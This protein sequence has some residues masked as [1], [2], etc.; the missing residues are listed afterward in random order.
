MAGRADDDPEK[1]FNPRASRL[2]VSLTSLNRRKE[3]CVE[4]KLI[5]SL[6]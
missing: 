4:E 6:R 2:A 5:C 1:T 3:E